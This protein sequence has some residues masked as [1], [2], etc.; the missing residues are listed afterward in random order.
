M[1]H[2]TSTGPHKQAKMVLTPPGRSFVRC[3]GGVPGV[4]LGSKIPSSSTADVGLWPNGWDIGSRD[5]MS[6]VRSCQGSGFSISEVSGS[7]NNF[8]V[9]KCWVWGDFPWS[10]DTIL[11]QAVATEGGSECHRLALGAHPL[12]PTPA[13]TITVHSKMGDSQVPGLGPVSFSRSSQARWEDT[14]ISFC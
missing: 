14:S 6:V 7:V 5:R 3:S 8:S 13:P 9:Y 4:Y 1:V 12:T 2:H 11:A 10:E